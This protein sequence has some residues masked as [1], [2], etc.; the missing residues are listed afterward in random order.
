MDL[1]L[2]QEFIAE[3]G[4]HL[5]EMET[6]L[7]QLETEP[8]NRE[9]LNDIFRC[10]HTI[11][12][13]AEYLGMERMAE[14]SHKLENLL[15]I[16][17]HGESVTD[18]EIMDT[19]M[20]AKDRLA[21][22]NEDLGRVQKEETDVRDLILRIDQLFAKA[23][24]QGGDE[25]SPPDA[26]EASV[27]DEA[28]LTES[29]EK[30]PSDLECDSIE[31]EKNR[32]YYDRVKVILY[33]MT[34]GE[35]NPK[36]KG[37]ILEL[38]EEFIR[39]AACE[40]DEALSRN[41]EK[42]RSQAESISFPD[43]AGDMLADLHRLM[44][45]VHEGASF[46]A[47]ESAFLITDDDPASKEPVADHGFPSLSAIEG[48]DDD[49]IYEE[50]YDDELFDIF[51]QHL[52]ENLSLLAGEIEALETAE[53][54]SDLLGKCLGYVDGLRSSANY[55][56]YKKLSQLYERWIKD[57]GTAREA[58]SQGQDPILARKGIRAFMESY[59][60]EILKRF[61]KHD[62]G[63]DLS[64]ED[65][66][67]IDTSKLGEEDLSSLGVTDEDT[68]EFSSSLTPEEESAEADEDLSAIDIPS[69]LGDTLLVDDDMPVYHEDIQEEPSVAVLPDEEE[70]WHEAEEAEPASRPQADYQGLFD[71]LDD[72]FDGVAPPYEEHEPDVYQRDVEEKL[73]SPPHT[74]ASD[75]P[76][77]QPEPVQA[78]PTPQA[79]KPALSEGPPEPKEEKPA[80]DQAVPE[81]GE[82]VKPATAPETLSE[83]AVKPAPAQAAFEPH[84]AGTSEDGHPG[85]D[86]E[87]VHEPSHPAMKRTLR[88]DAGKIDA[89]M[90][91]VGELV[92]SRAWFSQLYNEM[93]DLQDQ[94]HHIGL[95]QREMK[96][97][98]ALTFK[99]SEATVA[100]GRVANE[101]QEGVMKVRMLPI[102]Q[103]FNRYPRLVRDL[104]HDTH[105]KKQI[106][107]E[108]VGEET[109]L[110]RMVIEEISDPLIHIIRNAVD[111]GCETVDERR[112]TGKPGECALKLESYH[113]SNHV[114]IEISDNGRGI[115]PALVR[116]KA[117]EKNFLTRDELDRM[118]PRELLS[119]IMKPGFSTSEQVSKTSGRG[120]GMDVVKKNVE[121]LNGT[122]E[123]ESK[124]RVGTRIRIK[125][126]LTL[127]IIQALLVRVGQDIFTIPLASVEETLRIFEHE[128]SMIEGVEVIHLRDATLSLLR[129][130]EIFGI[131]DGT[132]D[133]Y[134]SFVVVVNT[135]MRRMGLVVDAL[136]GQEETVIKPLVDY[137]QENSGFSGATILGDGRIS[138]ILDVYEL[139]NMSIGRQ[140]KRKNRM[141]TFGEL[142]ESHLSQPVYEQ[143][144][145]H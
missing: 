74:R 42:L 62:L 1:S 145:I 3:T 33:E 39:V 97:V 140:I 96:P 7:L 43:D 68:S 91:Q 133:T 25:E 82:V 84:E 127:A 57:I 79:V 134:K 111:H 88:V 11:K 143:R 78:I 107:L 10:A 83:Q 131:E 117:L 26:E 16:L 99:L 130:S 47:E 61:S 93:R 113:E 18:R 76:V 120:V 124:V 95:D 60:R 59:V 19:L 75:T 116:K 126:P 66:L 100:L 104:V 38:L 102:A 105:G 34:R 64:G 24:D 54:Q 37:R 6:N 22:L 27:I 70:S 81:S 71:E 44:P 103:L 53:D 139:I 109:E 56:D 63:V 98:K 30:P 101:L 112:M 28:F 108:I 90:N 128:I 2:L 4:E 50:E 141:N 5:E 144:T 9:T 13:S 121:K 94:L 89:L 52:K 119:I 106:R 73:T 23:S 135:G 35:I 123:I 138:L 129:L 136:I 118:S 87:D 15:E 17:R 80:P 51:F 36:N 12:G 115:D 67:S 21:L 122:I 49:E 14:L 92:V 40:A 110:D 45:Q 77:F 142:E 69:E 32:Q 132:R 48:F 65:L 72:A 114:V 20:D 58:L 86:A 125:I 55:M 31:T 8:D 46:K 85:E 41:L 29:F 137:L